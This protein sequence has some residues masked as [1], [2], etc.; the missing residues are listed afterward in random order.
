MHT[1]NIELVRKRS[2][3]IAFRTPRTEDGTAVWR[4]IRSCDPLD[5][6]SLYCNLLQCDHFS[7]TCMVA[8]RVADG[9][10]VGWVSGYL[11]P[12]DPSLLFIW[13]V[14]VDESAQ[15]QGIAKRMLTALLARA[16]CADVRG[17]KTTIT[18]DNA[19]SWAL[20]NSFARSQ[21]TE[22]KSEPYFRKDAH[23]DG[24][25]ATEHMVTITLPEEARNAA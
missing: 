21:G 7:D 20:F 2:G 19:A 10:I 3:R 16:A 12:D 8:E 15:G 23:F 13:Q 9:A 5:E 24:E 4:L 1:G 18:S 25:H 14:A 17:L 22:L 6:N 11:L